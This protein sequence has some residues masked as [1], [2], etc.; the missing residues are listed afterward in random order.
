MGGRPILTRRCSWCCCSRKSKMMHQQQ[1][2]TRQSLLALASASV[3]RN[4]RHQRWLIPQLAWGSLDKVERA[5]ASASVASSPNR[6]ERQSVDSMVLFDGVVG[7]GHCHCCCHRSIVLVVGPLV[8]ALDGIQAVPHVDSHKSAGRQDAFP[9]SPLLK[10][11]TPSPG[12]LPKQTARDDV[13]VD[14]EQSVPH[15]RT[16]GGGHRHH[17]DHHCPTEE[18]CKQ[19][20]VA[21]G[22]VVRLRWSPRTRPKTRSTKTRECT[23]ADSSRDS[24]S[25][26]SCYCASAESS[27]SSLQ[28]TAGVAALKSSLLLLLSFA[29]GYTIEIVSLSTRAFGLVW[30]AGKGAAFW[31][32]LC[33]SWLVLGTWFFETKK[34]D[35]FQTCLRFRFLLNGKNSCH[36]PCVSVS[37][38]LRQPRTPPASVFEAILEMLQRLL[39]MFQSSTLQ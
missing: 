19:A 16:R 25:S 29:K 34:K 38:P 3:G 27:S 32:G 6:K 2:K 12:S 21:R 39:T 10:V 28:V 22:G 11:G 23:I 13:D 14:S 15:H 5:N 36:L 30:R 26:S 9:P 31:F 8:A 20:G 35:S 24:S 33:V 17:Q 37:I 4:Y 7:I 1:A 18:A